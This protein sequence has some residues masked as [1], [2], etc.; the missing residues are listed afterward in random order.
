MGRMLIGTTIRIAP[1]FGLN[2]LDPASRLH[3]PEVPV[4]KGDP[5][6]GLGQGHEGMKLIGRVPGHG[7]KPPRPT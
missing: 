3:P 2:S 4:L 1:P 6:P 7:G 5:Y